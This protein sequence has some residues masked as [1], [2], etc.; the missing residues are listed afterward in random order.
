MSPLAV[1]SQFL[2][3]TWPHA[4]SVAYAVHQYV[5]A[6]AQALCYADAGRAS[7]QA[8]LLFESL[9]ACVCE[10]TRQLCVNLVLIAHKSALSAA[11]GRGHGSRKDD[12]ARRLSQAPSQCAV[13]IG[14][15]VIR[16]LTRRCRRSHH[17]LDQR[18]LTRPG[19]QPVA[20][21]AYRARGMR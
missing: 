18:A 17:F 15:C 4:S 13:T 14:L 10:Q 12:I 1:L 8:R 6:S 21:Q 20:A 7:A 2:Q 16:C 19:P 9:S 3:K 5:R 11:R